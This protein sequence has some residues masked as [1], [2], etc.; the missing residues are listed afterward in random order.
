MILNFLLELLNE[1]ASGI[2]GNAAR[3]DLAPGRPAA[4]YLPT[5]SSLLAGMPAA[6]ADRKSRLFAYIN[7]I[8]PTWDRV[9]TDAALRVPLGN[10]VTR[11]GEMATSPVTVPDGFSTAGASDFPFR[12]DININ[13][14]DDSGT[15]TAAQVVESVTGAASSDLS[16]LA[17][18]EETAVESLIRLRLFESVVI[19]VAAAFTAASLV[20]RPIAEALALFRV[21]GN[22]GVWASKNSLG[23]E[24]PAET[25][26]GF[27]DDMRRRFPKGER[28]SITEHILADITNLV[29]LADAG[30]AG[31]ARLSEPMQRVIALD[32]GPLLQAIGGDIIEHALIA[33]NP[34]NVAGAATAWAGVLS[35]IWTAAGFDPSM[36]TPAFIGARWQGLVDNM[37]LRRSSGHDGTANEALIV[38]P[39]DPVLLLRNLLMDS[40]AIYHSRRQPSGLFNTTTTVRISD[41]LA[42]IRYN[43]AAV[44]GHEGAIVL[45]A[46]RSAHASTRSAVRPL[47]QAIQDD[48]GLKTLISEAKRDEA[49]VKAKT[50][51]TKKARDEAIEAAAIASAAAKSGDTTP[52]D[53]R[54]SN[55]LGAADHLTLLAGFI[56]TANTNEWTGWTEHRG[57]MHRFR[58]LLDYY[59]RVFG[60]Y[61]MR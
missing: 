5:R 32:T 43:A 36:C 33:A 23:H 48:P 45:S 2:G 31:L 34:T 27:N 40:L 29:W 19:R 8:K 11:A 24:V 28:T 49:A 21:E 60:D 3:G 30:N 52:L 22:L 1:I 16:P 20:N 50:F 39:E 7:D 57:N 9:R 58:R 46:V 55:W 59:R 25:S 4:D 17:A 53:A 6:E 51:P 26:D 18:T 35:P 37:V 61:P 42:Y 10:A 41:S 56:E 54:L 13:L 14:P 38:T 47:R 44:S 15:L 12:L